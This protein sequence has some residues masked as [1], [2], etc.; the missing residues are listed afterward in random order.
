MP[1]TSKRNYDEDTVD[2]MS[3]AEHYGID[4]LSYPSLLTLQSD[5]TDKCSLESFYGKTGAGTK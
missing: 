2:A 5:R 1:C 4:M 3:V